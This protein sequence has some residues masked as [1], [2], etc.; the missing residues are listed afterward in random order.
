[1]HCHLKTK[2]RVVNYFKTEKW[3]P[4]KNA[5]DTQQRNTMGTCRYWQDFRITKIL[6]GKI[7]EQLLRQIIKLDI[8][9]YLH[10]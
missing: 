7:Q 8:G 4:E 6:N 9:N 2:R 1:M 10:H 5:S 3:N